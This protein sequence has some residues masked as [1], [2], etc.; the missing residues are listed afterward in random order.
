MEERVRR[1]FSRILYAA[2]LIGLTGAARSIVLSQANDRLAQGAEPQT[3]RP[4]PDSKWILTG[5]IDGRYELRMELHRKNDQIS[6]RYRYLNQ[7]K[8][9][10]LVLRGA[11]SKSG[12]AELSEY[13]QSNKKTGTFEGEFTGDIIGQ[14][15]PTKFVGG[16]TNAGASARLKCRLSSEVDE[17]VPTGSAAR[18]DRV[19]IKGKI[20]I[21]RQDPE[22]PVTKSV[23]LDD[24]VCCYYKQPVITGKQPAH[25]L[26]KIRVALNIQTVYESTMASLIEELYQKDAQGERTP[27]LNEI[28]IDYQVIYNENYIL[29]FSYERY[30]AF[31]RP[32]TNSERR[33][34]DLR[35]GNVVKAKD[36]FIPNSMPAL[37]QMADRR[38]QEA[39][40]EQLA[41]Y[42]AENSDEEYNNL[43]SMLAERSFTIDLL[44][45]FTVD[46]QGVTFYYGYGVTAFY[47]IFDT[48]ILT[49]EY[50]ELKGYIKPKGVLGQF[51]PRK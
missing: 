51:I 18:E 25:V 14:N 5:K 42:K 35:T 9:S 17:T 4:S 34:F 45:N 39:I 27:R 7:P 47:P 11:I 15:G 41:E 1:I 21:L 40:R 24:G 46:G 50:E 8:G 43:K 36:V 2:F 32:Q 20:H 6:G 12:Y 26:D 16:W 10:Y 29:S 28:N 33:V 38:F 44:D 31:P 22:F 23:V 48:E 3:Q 13:N 49:F 19:Y 30:D 37:A